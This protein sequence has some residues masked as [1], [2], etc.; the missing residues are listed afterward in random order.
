MRPFLQKVWLVLRTALL[1]YG[2][3]LLGLAASIAYAYLVPMKGSPFIASSGDDGPRWPPEVEAMKP[4]ELFGVIDAA[5]SAAL[6]RSYRDTL[7]TPEEV[8]PQ[9]YGA[10]NPPPYW[11]RIEDDF[12][13]AQKLG[14][15]TLPRLPDYAS[16]SQKE[17]LTLSHSEDSMNF[18]E[19]NWLLHKPF[20][21]VLEGIELHAGQFSLTKLRN[22]VEE[23]PAD[24]RESPQSLTPDE[25]ATWLRELYPRPV[26]SFVTNGIM[27]LDRA[28]FAPGQAY[29]EYYYLDELWEH[30]IDRYVVLADEY[31]PQ[32]AY[33]HG[34]IYYRIYGERQAIAEGVM[35][36]PSAGRMYRNYHRPADE[37]EGEE[38]STEE[39]K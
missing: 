3:L 32:Q 39:P 16:L 25:A 5:A 34:F 20:Q 23:L 26:L 22:A 8:Y 7:K 10:D 13:L 9:L 21:Q 30:L 24:A 11:R 1:L 35:V 17:R 12:A 15:A 2:I 4:D 33:D 29:V 28:E 27:R 14:L 18:Y 37:A 38:Q 19:M 36:Y 6:N 31:S